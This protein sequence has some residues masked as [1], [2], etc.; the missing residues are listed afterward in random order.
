MEA[1]KKSREGGPGTASRF[2]TGRRGEKRVILRRG[3]RGERTH[4]RRERDHLFIY[5]LCMHVRTRASPAIVSSFRRV[6]RLAYEFHSPVSHS[7]CDASRTSTRARVAMFT[8]ARD[9]LERERRDVPRSSALERRET[10]REIYRDGCD[11]DDDG[12]L[13]YTSP[14]PRD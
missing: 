10:N 9:V 1:G 14:S 2:R 5:L 11:D 8:S 12:C 6:C 4:A 13:L 3:R 7:R